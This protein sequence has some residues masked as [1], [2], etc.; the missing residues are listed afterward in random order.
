LK[1]YELSQNYVQL[2]E[3]A[4]SLDQE[5]FQDTL[6]SLEEAIEDKAE[7][8]AKLIKCL[9]SDCKAIKEEEQRLVDRRKALE[10][11]ISSIKE[12]LQNQMEV[13]GLNKVKRPTITISIQANPPSVEV[14]DESLIPSTYMVPQ[15][16]KIDKRAILTALKE[17]EFIPGASIKQ[18]MGVR[19]K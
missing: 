8:V 19:I 2:L 11:K 7:N 9:D 17:G 10:N 14:M 1:L 16:S 15:P 5:T 13:A 3:L 12:Y 18:S 4:D 6:S